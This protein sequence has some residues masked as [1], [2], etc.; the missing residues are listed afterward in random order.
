MAEIDFLATLP[1]SKRKLE[2]RRLEKDENVID[3]AREFGESYFDGDR[4]YGYG[5]YRYDG[6]WRSVAKS[7]I[8][9]YRLAPG[10]RVLDIGCAKGFLVKDLMIECPGL[11]VYGLDISKYALENCEDEVVGRL[12]LGDARNLPF[13]N[14]SFDLVISINTIHNFERAEVIQAL[15]EMVRVGKKNQYVVV[16]SYHTAAQKDVFE[17]W[18]LTARFYDYPS[19]WIDVFEESGYSGDYSWTIIE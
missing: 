7:L 6:R 16:D 15:R 2:E 17:S 12:H 5:G 18:V 13:P 4:K 14:S 1:K 10:M 11:D 19:G 9:H 3:I 8:N